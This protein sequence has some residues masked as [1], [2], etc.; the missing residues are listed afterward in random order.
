[1]SPRLRT[2]FECRFSDRLGEPRLTMASSTL[3]DLVAFHLRPGAALRFRLGES[4]RDLIC[5]H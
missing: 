3:N 4:E 5:D 1:L 2:P